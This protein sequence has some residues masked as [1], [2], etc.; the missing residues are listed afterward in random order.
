[1]SIPEVLDRVKA[2]KAPMV[3]I[4][5]GEPLLQPGVYPLMEAL[6]QQRYQVL[7]ETSGSID[8]RLVPSEVYKIVDWKTPSSK[9]SDR[10]D[11]RNI[12][13]MNERDELKFVIGSREDYEFSRREI[14]HHQLVEKPFSLLFSTVFGKLSNRDLAEWIIEDKLPVRFQLQQHK[15]VWDPAARGV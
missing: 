12:E 8:V 4:T 15:Y 3:E 7:L 9:E 13:S 6:L 2:L 5:G 1:M 10:N 11:V 14:E